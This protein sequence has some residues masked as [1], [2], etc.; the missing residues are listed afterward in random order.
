MHVDDAIRT[1]RSHKMFDGRTIPAD[2][3]REVIAL[4]AWAPNH[5]RTEPWRFSVAHGPDALAALGEAAALLIGEAKGQ[6][7]RAM[8]GTAA[9]AIGV[10]YVTSPG[11]PL[12]DREDFAATACAIENLM[13]A[14]VARGLGSYWTTSQALLDPRLA[15][16]WRL[17]AGEALIGVVVLGGP[18]LE[19]PAMRQKTVDE[20][21]RWL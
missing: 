5:K 19:M 6:K 3:L 1:R 8:L 11:D 12:R 20:I 4:A 2:L 21:T 10:A 16:H 18:A 15:G 9:A 17:G 7:L 14:L 13:L